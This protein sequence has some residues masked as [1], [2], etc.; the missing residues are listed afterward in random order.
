MIN[1]IAAA[2]PAQACPERTGSKNILLF[3][4]PSESKP[5]MLARR[6]LRPNPSI[7]GTSNIRLR[8]L[9]AAPHVKR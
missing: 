9:S 3:W 6:T 7:E 5:F 1:S 2:V 8:L 4:L